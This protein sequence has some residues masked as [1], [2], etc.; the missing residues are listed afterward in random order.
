V[1]RFATAF[2]V[3]ASLLWAVPA[4]AV[5]VVIVGPSRPSAG[6][7]ETVVRIRGE[8]LS[9]GFAVE[10]VES[11]AAEGGAARDSRDSLEHLAEQ[12][13]ADAVVAIVGQ[14][15][16]DSVEVWVVDKLTG[17]SVVGK[18][19]FETKSARAPEALAIRA[20]EL[21][22]S[23]F[24][25][26]DLAANANRKGAAAPPPPAV[27]RFVEMDRQSAYPERFGVELGGAGLVGFDGSGVALLPLV[28]LCVAWGSWFLLRATAAGLGTRPSVER[29]LGSAQISQ[30]FA[31]L[32][33]S[34]RF[35]SGRRLRPFVALSAGA[36]HTSV[37]GRAASAGS[38][39][40]DEGAWSFL[41]DGSF[42][43][44]M[45]LR[46]RLY[47]SLAVHAQVAEPYPAVQFLDTVVA[48]S[49]HPSLLATLAVGAW[50]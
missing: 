39:G 11:T 30:E 14:T 28:G 34:V 43:L 17:K 36:L 16:P 33:G 29:S 21:L 7:A 40:R 9:A 24:L 13:A 3:L 12:R 48:T 19:P 10:V 2:I 4:F 31:T 41:L 32:G 6:M 22:R 37:E 26:I 25:E 1:G 8:L 50:L 45:P 5:T 42:G 46:D 18:L 47:L 15:S 49:G 38:Q 44:T 27:V 35:R 23:S 20:I